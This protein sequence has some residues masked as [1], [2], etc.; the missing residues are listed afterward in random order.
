[1][2]NFTLTLRP[3][4]RP[5][6]SL[7]VMT[8]LLL[9]AT[10][11]LGCS[12]PPADPADDDYPYW[13]PACAAF[14]P[15]GKMA[16]VADGYGG[17]RLYDLASGRKDLTLSRRAPKAQWAES[18]VSFSKDGRLALHSDPFRQ[19]FR[20][21]ETTKGQLLHNLTLPDVL[22]LGAAFT[23]DG[24]R[25]V[26]AGI[27]PSEAGQGGMPLPV[28][29]SEGVEVGDG[30]LPDAKHSSGR[31]I[32]PSRGFV[33]L[34]DL[35]DGTF[36]KEL[37]SCA[38]CAPGPVALAPD[39]TS[40][41]VHGL[42]AGDWS[43]K[44][45]D[46]ATGREL[47]TFEGD[48]QQGTEAVFHPDGRTLLAA[49]GM[50]LQLWDV[51]TGKVIKTFAGGHHSHGFSGIAFTPDGKQ[52]LTVWS[53]KGRSEPRDGV[54]SE[55]KM[56]DVATGEEIPRFTEFDPQT[57]KLLSLHVSADGTRALTVGSYVTLWDV[58]TGKPVRRLGTP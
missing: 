50:E 34:Y 53:W 6:A 2:M 29:T 26:L 4:L 43:L 20:V 5:S 22:T 40:V 49:A 18:K 45:F 9:R 3:L 15:D 46:L 25:I 21:W 52:A 8:L 35:K 33:R 56:W 11:P 16:V 39:D 24:Q 32:L 48:R 58:A 51:Q 41:V 38:R 36:V 14:A 28:Y 37:F 57:E 1:M 13:A 55:F 44:L 19:T 7:L 47:R 12:K 42:N 27:E 30:H 17:V 31:R 23:S 10:T 54:R